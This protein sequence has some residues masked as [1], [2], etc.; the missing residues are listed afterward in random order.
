[1]KRILL[2]FLAVAVVA[3]VA[4]VRGPGPDEAPAASHGEAPFSSKDPTGDISDFYLFRSPDRPGTVTAIM[5]VN[6]FSDPSAGPYWFDFDTTAKYVMH[7]DRT[8]DGRADVSYEFRFRNTAASRST[9]LPLGC[10]AGVCQRYNVWRV[11]GSRGTSIGRNLPVAPTNIGPRTRDTFEGGKSYE[12]IRGATVRDLRRGGRVF[13]GPA[14]DPFFGDIG[15]AF[16]AIGFRNGTGN[17]GG[18]KDTF[19]G[20]N[21]HTIAI[22]IPISE[23][24]G[25]GDV[26][27]AWAAVYRPAQSVRPLAGGTR[28]VQINRLGNP[29]LNELLIPTALKDRWNR[30]APNRDSQYTRYLET[31]ALAAVANSLYPTLNLN[32]PETDR[33]DLV[34]AFHHGLDLLGNS[35]G[36]VAAD[37]LRLNL[38]TPPAAMPNRLGPLAGDVAGWPN[39]RRLED[40]TIDIAL[41]ALGGALFTPPNVLPLGDGVNANEKAYLSAFPYVAIPHEG[42]AN[43]HGELKPTTP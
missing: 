33:A 27:G 42:F 10:V 35:T 5:N 16:D 23:I 18:G 29:L 14:D 36:T 41:I 19:A 34:A 3:V 32:I 24:R 22:Q 2:P 31:P 11:V 17:M 9:T 15:A 26:V 12:Q 7:F 6:P 25:S 20:Y 38:S 30:T 40:D 1:M 43:S 13:A 37:M 8:G 4:V 28:W 39:G 21:V